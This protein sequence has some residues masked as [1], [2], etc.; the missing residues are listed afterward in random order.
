MEHSGQHEENPGAMYM[1]T[2]VKCSRGIKKITQGKELEVMPPS[3]LRYKKQHFFS[4][5]TTG[6]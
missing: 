4:I 6:W 1:I 5:Q 2:G 3:L